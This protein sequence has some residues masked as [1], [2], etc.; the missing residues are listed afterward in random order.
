[1]RKYATICLIFIFFLLGT[2]CSLTR[3]A[4]SPSL[5]PKQNFKVAATIPPLGGIARQIGGE[6]IEIMILLPPGS[7]PHSFEPSPEQI[8]SLQ[9]ADLLL[10]IGAGLDDWARRLSAGSNKKIKTLVLTQGLDLLQEAHE[11]EEQSLKGNPHIW[12][13]PIIVRDHIA[14]KIKEALAELEPQ[15]ESYFQI[16]LKRFQE[17]IT[18][19]DTTIK[20]K[21]AGAKQKNFIAFHPAWS[22]FAARYG[23]KEIAVIQQIP[24]QE[25]SPREMVNLISLARE[26]QKPP[27]ILEPQFDPKTGWLL[28]AEY[29]GRVFTL[30]PL[31]NAETSYLNLMFSNLE[32]WEK[33]LEIESEGYKK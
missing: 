22:Y 3:P 10:Q 33:A 14:I 27:V 17:E 32:I 19:L 28:A 5:T 2:A 21:L 16:N 26:A 4:V 23:L 7:N 20:Q 9:E 24:G 13:D 8:K 1:M 15:N 12:L 18:Q 31:G 6:R 29:H 30:D 11:G 25:P